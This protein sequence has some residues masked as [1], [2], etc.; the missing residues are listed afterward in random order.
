MRYSQG[1]GRVEF[2]NQALHNGLYCRGGKVNKALGRNTHDDDDQEEE[3][4]SPIGQ[5]GGADICTLLGI[6]AESDADH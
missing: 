5:Q 2:I 1:L 3:D 4:R 6:A